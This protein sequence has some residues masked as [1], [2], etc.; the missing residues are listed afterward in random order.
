MIAHLGLG[1]LIAAPLS[2]HL[3][4]AIKSQPLIKQ[5]WSYTKPQLHNLKTELCASPQGQPNEPLVIPLLLCAQPNGPFNRSGNFPAT[6]GTTAN[7]PHGLPDSGNGA[8]SFRQI[9]RFSM[10]FLE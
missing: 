2:E 6:A 3:D 8:L 4:P 7:N 9:P 5:P 1:I 10:G